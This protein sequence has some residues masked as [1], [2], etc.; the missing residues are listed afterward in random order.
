MK[1]IKKTEKLTSQVFEQ[2]KD[3]I[4]T[5]KWKPGYKIPSENKLTE[6]LNVSRITIR[7]ALQA[8][9]VLDLLEKKRGQGTF[10]KHSFTDSFISSL[11][12]LIQFD[13]SQAVYM[14]EYRKIVEIGSI[15]LVVERASLE[16]IQR[17]KNILQEMNRYKENNLEKFAFEDLNFHLA[18]SQITKNPIIIRANFV[19][20][21]F[22]RNHMIK[23]V[24]AMGTEPGLYFH[25]KIIQ[26]IEKRDKKEA[27]KLMK[28][29][30]E[31]NEKYLHLYM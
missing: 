1:S 17:L 31:N 27:R 12:P 25:E 2:L 10:V 16:D 24:E 11:L 26:A 28:K 20:K 7:E 5:G 21:D 29:H 6:I 22:F 14:H 13:R 15:E 18:L 23:I 30:L 8:L 3:Q 19:I 4:I 9:V